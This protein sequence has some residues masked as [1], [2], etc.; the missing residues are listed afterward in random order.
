MGDYQFSELLTYYILQFVINGIVSTFIGWDIMIEIKE[1][2][3]ANYLLKPMD[4]LRWQ[5]AMSFSAKSAELLYIV[6]GLATVGAFVARFLV[7]PS[8]AIA[9]LHSVALILLATTLSFFIDFLVG[10]SAFWLTDSF[11]FKFLS[12]GISRFFA[13]SVLPLSLLPF[14]VQKIGDFLP[15]QYLLYVP[16]Q[17]YLGRIQDVSAAYV[18]SLLWIVALF[19]AARLALR[20]GVRRFEAVGT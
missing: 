9:L 6:V 1:G 11:G 18:G 2:Y 20:A 19:I 4:Y 16:I 13:G 10:I 17:I 12:M 15:F 3:F 8:S 5:A 14:A 7:G